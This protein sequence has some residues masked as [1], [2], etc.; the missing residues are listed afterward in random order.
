MK[1]A[2][3]FSIKPK[4]PRKDVPCSHW[5]NHINTTVHIITVLLVCNVYIAWFQLDS[6]K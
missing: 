4:N 1:L 6:L 3:S 5:V 2:V